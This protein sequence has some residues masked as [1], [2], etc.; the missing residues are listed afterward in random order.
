[1]KWT[2][3]ERTQRMNSSAIR[4]LLKVTERLGMIS[5]AET[6]SRVSSR[7]GATPFRRA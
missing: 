7:Q 3:A 6:D 5:I 4:E 2:M 1:M